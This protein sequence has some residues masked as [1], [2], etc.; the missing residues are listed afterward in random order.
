M[1]SFRDDES[2]HSFQSLQSDSTILSS[3]QGEKIFVAVRLRPLDDK[4]IARNE[5]SEW[6]CINNTTIMHNKEIP[7]K[8]MLPTTYVFD[9]VFACESS[10]K[11]VYE[12]GLKNVALSVVTGINTSIFAYGQTSSGKTYTMRGISEYA[13]ADIFDYVHEHDEREF[14]LKFSAIEIYNESVRDLLGMDSTPLRLLDDPER[15]TVVEKLTEVTVRDWSHL[16]ELMAICEAER[17]IGETS[18]NATSSRSHQIIRLTVESYAQDFSSAD[19]LS[20]LAASVSFVD[21]AGSERSSQTLAVGSRLKEGSHINRSLLTL[22]T[23]IRKLRHVPFRDSKLTRILQNSLGGNARTAIICTM[24]PAHCHAEQSRNTLLFAACAKQVSTNA[25]VNV[26]MSE[27]ALIKHLQKQLAS[28]ENELRIVKSASSPGDS[29]SLLR[30]KELLIEKM[31]SDIRDLTRE[32]DLAQSRLQEMLESTSDNQVSETWVSADRVPDASEKRSWRNENSVSDSSKVVDPPP[33]DVPSSN[34][35][36]LDKSQSHNS[37]NNVPQVFDNSDDFFLPHGSPN[38]YLNKYFGPDLSRGWEEI[39]QK[40]YY[41][42]EVNCKEVQYVNGEPKTYKN[43]ETATVPLP[44]NRDGNIGQVQSDPTSE[45][46]QPNQDK[47]N[48]ADDGSVGP[49]PTELSPSSPD[50]DASSLGN[51]KLVKSSSCRENDMTVSLIPLSQEYEK[52]TTPHNE[53]EVDFPVKPEEPVLDDNRGKLSIVDSSHESDS[54]DEKEKN[55]RK[56]PD[57]D[58]DSLFNGAMRDKEALKHNYEVKYGENTVQD[59]ETNKYELMKIVKGSNE[60]RYGPEHQSSDWKLEFERQRKQIIRLWDACY[61]PLV[62]RSFFFLL[63]QGDPSD[64]VYLEVEYRRLSFLM[65]T[66]S[67]GTSSGAI[68]RERD[69]LSHQLLKKY[70]TKQRE[71]LYE[72]WG[73]ELNSKQRRKQLSRKLWKDTEDLDHVKASASL[74]AKLVGDPNQ[75]PKETFGL[76]FAPQHGSFALPSL[77]KSTCAPY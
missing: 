61:I 23:V 70:R 75:A 36:F 2:I 37:V 8:S 3:A 45:A 40:N 71:V 30:E 17:Q 21:L 42:S 14:V 41:S 31:D 64:S 12:D 66:T 32:R 22:G 16:K 58:S 72:K 59:A 44:H 29:S 50:N 10:T 55:D 28:L 18:L 57:S 4:E 48:I 9:K 69:M 56:R 65:Q 38:A 51:N 60:M 67:R 68:D 46:P 20:S 52:D 63:F 53:Y 1:G 47:K 26:V 5:A 25:Q 77:R 19:D 74:V 73:I 11:E 13:M 33:L 43:S 34:R 49:K 39:A 62:H 24:S 7:E 35:N 54:I 15:G 76:S 27:K 6:E